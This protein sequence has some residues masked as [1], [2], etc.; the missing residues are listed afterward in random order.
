[1][2]A[3]LPVLDR[4]LEG[5]ARLFLV[6]ANLCLLLMLIGTT[7][8]ILGRPVGISFYW[9]YP[10]TMQ[11]FV[12]MAFLGFFAVYRRGKDIAVDFVMRRIGPGAMVASRYFAALMILVVTG[13]I[14]SQMPR[15]LD[16]QVGVIDG[17]ITPWGWELERFTL[18][19]PLA[20]SSGLIFLNALAELAKAALGWP[21]IMPDHHY[22]ADE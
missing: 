17:V 8:T 11:F 15:L 13:V 22:S 12:W 16:T 4:V 6:L 3:I 21:E 19:W 10:W 5:L 2:N 18:T 20:V 1:M 9:M 14:L 7:I